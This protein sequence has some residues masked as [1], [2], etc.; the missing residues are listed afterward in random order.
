MSWLGILL[1][2]IVGMF[3]A[4]AESDGMFLLGAIIGYCLGLIVQLNSRIKHLETQLTFTPGATRDTHVSPQP[5][6][7]GTAT[8]SWGELAAKTAAAANTP[9]TSRGGV[10]PDS[11][12]DA[13]DSM[14]DAELAAM[15]AIDSNQTFSRQATHATAE[16]RVQSQSPPPPPVFLEKMLG[17]LKSFFTDGNVVVK[18]GLLVLFTGVGFL[19]KYAAEHSMLPVEIRAIGI[20]L[21]GMAL[22]AVGWRLRHRKG[23]YALL[24]QGGGVGVMY[25]N[26]F[27]A[28]KLYNLIP[29]QG[30]LAVMV[31]LV[32][33]SGLLAVLQNA[34][35]LAF[36]G[37]AGGF[38]AP[39]L[40]STGGGSHVMLFSYYAL[41][42]LGIVG[43]AWHRSWRELNLLGFIFT[44]A[45]GGIWGAKFYQPAFFPSV[46]PFLIL[47]FIL[48]VTIAVLFALRQPVQLKG[49]ID[50]SL[51]FGVPVI[52]FGMQTALVDEYEYGLAFS[53]L[54]LSGFYILLAMGL[55]RRQIVGM[56]LLTEA[57]LAMGVVFGTLA[58]PLALDGRWASI[59]WALEGA[60]IVWVG[61]RQQRVLP[62]IFGLMLQA[63][64]GVFFFDDMSYYYSELAFLN[65]RYLGA[66]LL[67]LAGL[68]SSYYLYRNTN[69]LR[70]WEKQL[71]I[72]LLAWGLLWWFASAW[73]EISAHVGSHNLEPTL[74]LIFTSLTLGL[75]TL[76]QRRLSWNTL[77]Y[78]V[79]GHV[80]AA[81]IMLGLS[82]A[83]NNSHPLAFYGWMAW[84]LAAAVQY[85][86]LY[87]YRQ[88][89]KS[90]VLQWQH[91][92]SF[93]IF[94]CIVTWECAWWI[95]EYT[96]GY[97]WRDAIQLFVPTLAL[98]LL[99]RKG[100][101]LAWPVN[102]HFDWYAGYAAA[103]VIILLGIF[104]LLFGLLHE[105][106]AWPISY[107]PL[108][109]PVDLAVALALYLGILWRHLLSAG[110]L[111]N[112]PKPQPGWIDI[113][114]AVIGFCWLNGMIAR[115]VHH[116]FAIPHHLDTLA[117]SVIFQASISVVWT[118]TSLI[119]MFI[120]SRVAMRRVWFAG[121]GLFIVVVGKLFLIDIAN[122]NE[123]VMIVSL[124][125]VA[126]ISIVFG[127]YLSPLPPRQQ[128]E[129]A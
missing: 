32:A 117:D 12:P 82:A 104:A 36:Y 52:A 53:A 96:V 8:D 75:A 39:V 18:V 30:A 63:G 107:L 70:P 24:L 19:I 68:F 92:I 35:Y 29:A 3:S 84:P 6:P 58:I 127:Y 65:G 118:L 97:A 62:R 90:A 112:N 27:G 23:I 9:T 10:V 15:Y 126:I 111:P 20:G 7:T 113:S 50:G 115:S 81:L 79:L 99:F 87:I 106:D 80:Y 31:A 13:P 4:E 129:K 54:A 114:V 128:G 123:L 125:T 109:N 14:S 83:G 85:Y 16:P 93:W 124:I 22:L 37:A 66:L 121:L 61:I 89:V 5:S 72:G 94:L 103:P 33:L 17:Y 64:A 102:A 2:I 74:F 46:E 98:V 86:L 34:K 25:L 101:A 73:H 100:R 55:W 108:V 42:N 77:L 56:R 28:A 51:V 122:Q 110:Q 78:P 95:E 26:V 120:A 40:A 119:I 47:F 67:S 48:F 44:F 60:A 38:L 1:A 43:I 76:V 71:H 57:F 49:Y 91:V 21:T 59:A 11:I 69:E 41:L 45:I 88:Q 105:G 116:W